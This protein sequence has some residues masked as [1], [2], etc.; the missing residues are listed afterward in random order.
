MLQHT[1]GLRPILKERGAIFLYCQRCTQA[2]LHHGNGREADQPVK[3]KAG[4]MEDL[5]GA[6]VEILPVFPWHFIRV[7]MVDI[8]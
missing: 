4:D 5:I 2:V 7:G 8:I 1:A 3:A 6:E